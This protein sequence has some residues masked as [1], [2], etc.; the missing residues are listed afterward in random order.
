MVVLSYQGS[1]LLL[2]R[3]PRDPDF[4]GFWD[5]PGGT[6]KKGESYARGA[7]RELWE[8]GHVAAPCL[9]RVFQV[10]LD[11]SSWSGT[12]VPADSQGRIFRM[13]AFFARTS[14]RSTVLTDAREHSESMWAAPGMV[15]RM[16]ES[17][18]IPPGTRLVLRAAFGVGGPLFSKR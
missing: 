13:V 15:K 12:P 7:R 10:D 18:Q 14:V 8:E 3:E 5:F 4:P 17:G 11:D 9:R 2:R 16:E 1:I 6:A